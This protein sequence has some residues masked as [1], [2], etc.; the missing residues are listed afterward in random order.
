MC[1]SNRANHTHIFWECPKVQTYWQEIHKCLENIF[2]NSIDFSFSSLYFGLTNSKLKNK[3]DKYLMNILLIAS[4]KAITRKWLQPE[5][6]EINEWFEIVYDIYK[7]QTL[8]MNL[9][10]QA[11]KFKETW[12]K[13]VDYI[14]P[15]RP[16]LT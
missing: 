11:E 8:T 4:K 13:W 10:L 15:S 14:L 9:R 12:S 6:P 2:H 16:D 3:T 5:K 1:G 7:M